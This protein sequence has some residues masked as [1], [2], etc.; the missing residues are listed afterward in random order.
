MQ[1]DVHKTFPK[2]S[3]VLPLEKSQIIEIATFL[4][5]IAGSLAPDGSDVNTSI[6]VTSDAASSRFSID[7]FRKFFSKESVYTGLEFYSYVWATGIQIYMSI[8]ALGASFYVS[9]NLH[10]APQI[11]DCA[12]EIYRHILNLLP[13]PAPR[14]ESDNLNNHAGQPHSRHASEKQ[15]SK[16]SRDWS[17]ISAIWTILGVLASTLLGLGV[18]WGWF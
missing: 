2:A 14:D 15:C 1:H 16:N 8:N 17:K 5:G 12:E 11:E 9:S 18:H 7:E 6:T 13:D 4:S 3:I 10:T